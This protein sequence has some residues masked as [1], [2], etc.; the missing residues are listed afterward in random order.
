VTRGR[1]DAAASWK[2]LVSTLDGLPPDLPDLDEVVAAREELTEKQTMTME[3][4]RTD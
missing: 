2:A 1:W 4:V 3:A